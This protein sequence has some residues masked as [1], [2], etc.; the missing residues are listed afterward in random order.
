M[1]AVG[2]EHMNGECG[3]C[4]VGMMGRSE[5]CRAK[6]TRIKA[7]KQRSGGEMRSAPGN[8][9][10]KAA[11][12]ADSTRASKSYEPIPGPCVPCQ[13]SRGPARHGSCQR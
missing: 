4:D 2:C 12:K 13:P 8:R 3:V 7:W 9:V 11:I 1:Q 6:G 10:W 5:D